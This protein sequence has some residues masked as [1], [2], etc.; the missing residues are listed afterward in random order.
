MTAT[1]GWSALLK[2]EWIPL[3]VAMVGGVLLHSMNVLMLLATVLPSI[4]ADVG[5]AAMVSWPTTAFLASSIVAATCTG[6]LTVRLGARNAFCAGALVCRIGALICAAAPTMGVVVAGRFVQGFGGGVLSAMAY[7][8]VGRAFP[9]PVWPRVAALLSRAWSMAVLMGPMLGGAFVTWGNWRASFYAVTVLAALRAGAA[10]RAGRKGG[11]GAGNPRWPGRV[12]LSGD[13]HHV[14]RQRRYPAVDQ[15]GPLPDG[16]RLARNHD[17]PGPALEGA[18]ASER[19]LLPAHG[20]GHR[21]VVLLAGLDRLQPAVDLHPDLPAE[22]AR[23]RSPRR[24]LHGRRRLDWLDRGVAR[25]CGPDAARGRPAENRSVHGSTPPL[26]TI[27][28]K[29]KRASVLRPSRWPVNRLL[30]SSFFYVSSHRFSNVSFCSRSA[31]L[32]RCA[33]SPEDP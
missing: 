25:R 22:P 7:V 26:G 2:R 28:F 21:H 32:L 18:A 11:P 9:E 17:P 24:R 8:L 19:R 33:R 4:V 5:G 20:D 29:L 30:G 27:R 14:D 3:L 31:V 16:G 1:A 12:D 13:R 6:H 15:G 23:L 10:T